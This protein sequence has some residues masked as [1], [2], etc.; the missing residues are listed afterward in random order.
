MMLMLHRL[1]NC[2]L[3]SRPLALRT[4]SQYGQHCSQRCTHP[5]GAHHAELASDVRPQ[6]LEG[7]DVKD[8]LLNVGSGGGAAAAAPAAG[9]GS[10]PAA[11]AAPAAEE[12]KKEEGK[13]PPMVRAKYR[14]F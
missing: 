1:T 14:W 10:G 11:E 4:W 9:A 2:K 3:S 8:L 12:E 7:K 5:V 6:A 13:I